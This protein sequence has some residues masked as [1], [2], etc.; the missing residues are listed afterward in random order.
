[1][2]CTSH[3]LLVK[4]RRIMTTSQG[5]NLP[6]GAQ[7]PMP[8]IYVVSHYQPSHAMPHEIMIPTTMILPKCRDCV[9]VRFSFRSPP[10]E[11]IGEN[12]FFRT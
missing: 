2:A 1:M 4:E 5:S 7:A 9:G 12:E 8:G 6:A 10:I 11:L 3:Y